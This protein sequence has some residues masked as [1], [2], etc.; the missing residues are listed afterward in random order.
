M[1]GFSF[2]AA[3][4]AA[5]ASQPQARPD[6]AAGRTLLADGDALAYYCAGNGDTSSGQARRNLEQ[7]LESALRA[8]G[9]DKV[10]ILTTS[11]ASHKGHRYAISRIKPYQGKRDG[12]QRPRNWQ[13]MRELI[14]RD[15]RSVVTDTLEADDLFHIHSVRLGDDNVALLTMDKDMRMVPGWHLNWDSHALVRV[16]PDTWAAA[17]DGKLYG[18]KWFW[19]Q[20][21]MGDA[22]DNVPGLLACKVGGKLKRCG[23]KT[24]AALLRHCQDEHAAR[25]VVFGQ[26]LSTY[27]D[28]N[29]FAGHVAYI[30]QACLLWMRRSDRLFDCALPGG[31]LAGPC[32][33]LFTD[34]TREVRSRVE[35]L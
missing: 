4:A 25:D 8:C 27:G 35:D 30:E 18:R 33:P 28:G 13:L 16:Q 24:A 10:T 3:I 20:M 34:A 22:T 12:K 11:R 21:L 6:K 17:L 7:K 1:R 5:T 19:L 29:D 14:E 32:G 9:A 31:P 26:Y 23:E 2:A 15:P